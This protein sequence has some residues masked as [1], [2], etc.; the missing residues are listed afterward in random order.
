MTDIKTL[1]VRKPTRAPK[2]VIELPRE[3]PPV[4]EED[5]RLGPGPAT[6]VITP[7]VISE[8]RRKYE[9]SKKARPPDQAIDSAPLMR[10]S[11]VAPVELNAKT[12]WGLLEALSRITV[13][14]PDYPILSGVK[15]RFLSGDDPKMIFEAFNGEVWAAASMPAAGGREAF[16]AVLPLAR[17]ISILKLLSHEYSTIEVGLGREKIYVGSFGF[18]CWGHP[19]D[20]PKSPSLEPVEASVALSTAYVF[21][22]PRRVGAAVM[23]EGEKGV[24]DHCGMFLDLEKRV[25]VGTNGSRMHLLE[26]PMMQVEVEGGKMPPGLY[27]SSDV[28]RYMQAVESREWTGFRVEKTRLMVGS[29][30]FGL[31]APISLNRF[32]GWEQAVPVWQGAWQLSRDVLLSSLKEASLIPFVD[33]VRT[34]DL[35]FDLHSRKVTIISDAPSGDAFRKDLAAKAEGHLLPFLRVTANV[36]YLLDAIDACSGSSIRIGVGRELDPMTIQGDDNCFK[37]VIMPV[38]KTD[39]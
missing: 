12:F 21:D 4:F 32:L 15:V 38:R 2:G 35:A 29:E 9:E 36:V 30:D 17:T 26:L 14:N 39:D 34:V 6:E 16:E 20:F 37:A 3:S 22:I 23:H 25:A 13:E 8:S 19:S 5:V 1:V 10:N 11:I 18:P 33:E 28:F 27:I 7:E 31:I 24:R